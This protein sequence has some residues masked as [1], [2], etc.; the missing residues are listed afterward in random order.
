MKIERRTKRQRKR[1]GFDFIYEDEEG[2]RTGLQ[3]AE[4]QP[5]ENCEFSAGVTDHDFD[6]VFFKM[7]KDGH[8]DACF[9]MRP[10]E[11]LALARV[12]IGAVWSLEV[13]KT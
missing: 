10:D 5:Y 12:L 4:S 8:I 1:D 3:T 6:T 9:I 7:E 13:D 2:N 11:A